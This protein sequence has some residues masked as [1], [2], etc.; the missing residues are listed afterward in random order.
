MTTGRINQVTT[1]IGHEGLTAPG[2]AG[3]LPAFP[4]KQA[5]VRIGGVGCLAYGREDSTWQ[6]QTSFKTLW[7]SFHKAIESKTQG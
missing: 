4:K 6:S 5:Y 2:A 7:T 3:Y 1:L